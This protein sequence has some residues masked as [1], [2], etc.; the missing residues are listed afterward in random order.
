MGQVERPMARLAGR[1]VV[2]TGGASGIGLGM[3]QAFLAE[4]ARVVVADVNPDALRRAERT[5]SGQGGGVL[6]VGTDVSD[7]ESVRRLGQAA[8][9]STAFGVFVPLLIANP[10]G[11][12]IVNTASVGGLIAGPGT[13]PYAATKHAVVGLSRSLRAEL[14]MQKAP[15]GVTIVCPGRVATPIVDRLNARPGA[16]TGPTLPDELG[17]MAQAMR[18][19]AGGMTPTDAGRMIVDAVKANAAW[20]FPGADRHRPLVEQEF[21]QLLSAFPST[22]A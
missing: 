16:D 10:D 13:G 22:P 2:V 11:G 1:V 15:V 12:H 20:V 21:A 19:A 14:A 7:L 8:V 4:G 3:A 18:A 6:A 5:L 9:S 17:A